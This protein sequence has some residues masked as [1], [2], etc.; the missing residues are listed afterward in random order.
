MTEVDHSNKDPNYLANKPYSE[1]EL[2]KLANSLKFTG[3]LGP[4]PYERL[5]KTI[6][7]FKK[8]IT[9]VDKSIF[10]FIRGKQSKDNIPNNKKMMVEL[11]NLL[12]D[13]YDLERIQKCPECRVIVVGDLETSFWQCDKCKTIFETKEYVE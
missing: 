7:G 2:V 8:E 12:F 3:S 13:I 11:I 1:S 6:K 9:K 10:E 5:M 4:V